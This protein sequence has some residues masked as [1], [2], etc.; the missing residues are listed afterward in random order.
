MTHFYKQGVCQALEELGFKIATD[1][2]DGNQPFPQKTQTI[3]AEMLAS[4]LQEEEDDFSDTYPDNTRS[5]PWNKPVTWGSP[6]DL[7]GIEAGEGGSAGMMTPGSP[8]S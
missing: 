8:R 7:S 6:T 2:N 4:R 5:S 1:P 3:P